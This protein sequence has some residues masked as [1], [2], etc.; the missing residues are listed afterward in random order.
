M[1]EG[2]SVVVVKE[3]WMTYTKELQNVWSKC[4]T[5]FSCE[6]WLEK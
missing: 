4:R 2:V 3:N 1:D 5:V 6:P